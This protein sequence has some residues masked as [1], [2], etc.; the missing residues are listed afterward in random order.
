M[1][2][3]VYRAF[4]LPIVYMAPVAE[5]HVEALP[6]NRGAGALQTIRYPTH[7]VA[8]HYSQYKADNRSSSHG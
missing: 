6:T 4:F 7:I 3:G 8:H 2:R 1:K 5:D